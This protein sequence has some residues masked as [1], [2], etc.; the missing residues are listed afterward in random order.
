MSSAATRH[1]RL[2]NETHYASSKGAI[3]FTVSLAKE[4]G[5]QNIRV[6]ALRPGLI[7]TS[8]HESHGGKTAVDA[9]GSEHHDWQG[10]DRRRCCRSSVVARVR[11]IVIRP[12]LDLGRLRGPLGVVET[13]EFSPRNESKVIFRCRHLGIEPRPEWFVP[14]QQP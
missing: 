2:P 5:R 3:D 6:N 4:V 1:G 14:M 12:W 8:I 9:F 13:I 7:D 10:R 11:C